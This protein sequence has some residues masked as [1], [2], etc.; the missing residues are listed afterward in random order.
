MNSAFDLVHRDN[1]SA[2]VIAE[3]YKDSVADLLYE[4]IRGRPKTTGRS[5]KR[6]LEEFFA[7][8]N[9]HFRLPRVEGSTV[10]FGDIRRV[11]VVKFH[12]LLEETVTKLGKPPTETRQKTKLICIQ[13]R[14]LC[15]HWAWCIRLP[16]KRAGLAIWF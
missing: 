16:S 8:T 9:K 15:R 13:R 12:N 4:F 6:D 1:S 14:D 2:I 7:F 10:Y 5:Y 3:P 11:H